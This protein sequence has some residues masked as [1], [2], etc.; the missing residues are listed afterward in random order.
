M[1]L[2]EM[3]GAGHLGIVKTKSLA[4]SYLWWEG[5]DSDLEALIREYDACS[6]MKDAPAGTVVPWPLAEGP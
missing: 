6:R 5:I 3:H 2:E 4:R 1:L